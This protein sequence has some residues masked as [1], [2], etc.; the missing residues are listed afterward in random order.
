V[1]TMMPGG[2]IDRFIGTED[3]SVEE[4]G[5]ALIRTRNLNT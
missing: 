3:I 4:G 1:T 5:A 2:G